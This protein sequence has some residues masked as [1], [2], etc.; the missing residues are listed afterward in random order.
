MAVYEQLQI[1]PVVVAGKK[2]PQN[3]DLGH[4]TDRTRN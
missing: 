4:L 2:Q 3:A 1:K